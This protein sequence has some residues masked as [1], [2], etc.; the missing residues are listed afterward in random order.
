MEALSLQSLFLIFDS[1]FA[2]I[3]TVSF[4]MPVPA[5]WCELKNVAVANSLREPKPHVVLTLLMGS[6]SS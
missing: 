2:L 5:V 1:D 6:S 3:P 4:S